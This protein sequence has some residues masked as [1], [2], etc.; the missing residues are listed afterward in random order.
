MH[1]TNHCRRANGLAFTLIELLVVIALIA[2]LAGLLLP[3]LSKAKAKA[4]SVFCLNNLRQWGMATH[5][6]VS[7]HDDYLP[8]E[9][10][11]NGLSRESG[12]YINLPCELGIKPYYE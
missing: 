11:P 1:T 8:P 7:D 5:L 6:Y 3:A 4:R 9:G 10:S 2:T 12:W